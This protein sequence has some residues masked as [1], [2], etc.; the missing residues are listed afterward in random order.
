MATRSE[1]GG[2]PPARKSFTLSPSVNVVSCLYSSSFL[3]ILST[4][5]LSTPR[6]RAL[7]DTFAL[8][9]EASRLP[10][11]SLMVKDPHDIGSGRAKKVAK[12]IVVQRR[13][14]G[15]FHEMLDRGQAL[16]V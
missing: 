6:R 14:A 1:A 5:F 8:P 15:A 13:M 10:S 9:L 3:L 16:A 11:S 2:R 4:P 7:F 12:M